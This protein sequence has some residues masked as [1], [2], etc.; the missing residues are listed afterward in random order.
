MSGRLHL[1][2]RMRRCRLPPAARRMSGRRRGSTAH[3]TIAL[4]TGARRRTFAPTRSAFAREMYAST[5]RTTDHA[6]S[7]SETCSRLSA[8]TSSSSWAARSGSRAA[9]GTQIYTTGSNAWEGASPTPGAPDCWK[10]GTRTPSSNSTCSQVRWSA[11]N[12][13]MRSAQP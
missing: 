10:R 11:S 9:E 6:T 7:P 2:A 8:S 4:D 3:R 5:S 1:R 12:R 13:S